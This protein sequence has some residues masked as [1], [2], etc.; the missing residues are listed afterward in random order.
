MGP[1][2][3]QRAAPRRLC[4]DAHRLSDVRGIWVL[5]VT[6]SLLAI[7]IAVSMSMRTTNPAKVTMQAPKKSSCSERLLADW[8]DGRIDGTYSI[9]CYRIALKSLPLDL[10]VYSSA[11]DDISQALSQRI[12]QRVR[13][14]QGARKAAG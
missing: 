3:I 5:A 1:P 7:G 4:V 13:A 9:S 11:P 2:V 8:R 10:Q 6:V 14:T 12:V